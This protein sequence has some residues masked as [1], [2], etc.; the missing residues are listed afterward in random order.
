MKLKYIYQGTTNYADDYN[1]YRD[2]LGAKRLWEFAAFGANVAAF[3][4]DGQPQILLNDHT[5]QTRYIYVV[6]DITVAL[7]HLAARGV[8]IEEVAEG[9]TGACHLFTSPSG[10]LNAIMQETRP[11]QM[12]D[13]FNTDA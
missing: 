2:Q 9:P 5:T 13:A 1:F 4:L 12:V 10:T 3:E 8:T 6:E 7:E 11:D